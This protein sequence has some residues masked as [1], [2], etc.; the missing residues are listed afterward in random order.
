MVSTSLILLSGRYGAQV[1]IPAAIILAR[2]IG[3]SALREWMAGQGLRDLV[4]VGYQGKLKTALTMSA[5][6]LLLLVPVDGV[7]LLGK[8][9]WLSFSL[10]YLCTVITVTSASLYFRAAAPFLIRSRR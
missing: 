6:T 2:E 1:A 4:Q 7:G 3:V 9:R 5:L 10:L 8:L